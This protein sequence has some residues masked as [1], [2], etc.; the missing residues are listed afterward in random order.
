M[1]GT[2]HCVYFRSLRT[3]VTAI[4]HF[5]IK[6]DLYLKICLPFECYMWILCIK[7]DKNKNHT[8]ASELKMN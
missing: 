7:T 5:I 8:P 2:R 6:Q 4:L 3:N 1:V